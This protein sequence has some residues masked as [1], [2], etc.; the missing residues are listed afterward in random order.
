[1][2]G[3][4]D[5]PEVFHHH[6]VV[7]SGP[8]ADL[9]GPHRPGFRRLLV[10][11]GGVVVDHA[12]ALGVELVGQLRVLRQDA[13][14]EAAV[15]QK[16]AFPKNSWYALLLDRVARCSSY[17]CNSGS[18]GTAPSCTVGSRILPLRSRAQRQATSGASPSRTPIIRRIDTIFRKEN[19]AC[20]CLVVVLPPYPAYGLP[21]FSDSVYPLRIHRS[22]AV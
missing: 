6:L 19:D 16:N 20:G 10:A 4:Q 15:L 2:A 12:P 7:P 21:K 9:L 14:V 1:M 8:A 22:R 3:E 13:G 18:T 5:P 17:Y 11:F